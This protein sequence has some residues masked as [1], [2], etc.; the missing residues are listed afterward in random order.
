MIS[1][2]QESAPSDPGSGPDPDLD[3]GPVPRPNPSEGG[4]SRPERGVRQRHDDAY[5]AGRLIAYGLRPKLVPARDTRYAELVRRYLR[6]EEFAALTRATAAG[7][8][9]VVLDVA[10]RAGLVAGGAEESVFTVRMSDYARRAG[11][12]HRSAERL[13]HAIG[14][15][16]VAALAFPRPADL[17][18]DTYVGRVSVDGVD[19][20]VRE[21][22]RLLDERVCADPGAELDPRGTGDDRALEAAWRLY[23]RRPAAGTT[24]D[25]RRLAGSTTGIVAR[26]M[27]FLAESGCLVPVSDQAGGTFRTTARYQIQVRE[28]AADAALE[29]LLGLGVVTVSDGSGGVRVLAGTPVLPGT[30]AAGGGPAGTGQQAGT[31]AGA[32]ATAPDHAAGRPQGPEVGDV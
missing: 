14:Q 29:E 5:D 25:T 4:E 19:A 27:G 28:L 6:D 17:L 24:R 2:D 22:C 15:L 9:L 23:A 12:E 16:A 10:E 18:D 30:D 11:G 31:Q 32:E 13:L 21:A 1:L 20:F 26:A 8:G 7:L 3:P